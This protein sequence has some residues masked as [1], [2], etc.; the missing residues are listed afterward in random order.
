VTVHKDVLLQ[1]PFFAN[2][3]KPE[4]CD[5]HGDKPIELEDEDPNKFAAYVQWLYTHQID[6]KFDTM[7]WATMYV[8]GEKLMDLEFQD[9]VLEV[10]MRGCDARKE[11]LNANDVMS[12]TTAP[13][14][15]RQRVS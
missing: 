7:K 5:Q 2:A 6:T 14:K 12:F 15:S 8:L 1:S 9:D 11:L 3:L 10:L 13:R 4:W